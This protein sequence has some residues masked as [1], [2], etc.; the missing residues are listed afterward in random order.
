MNC[1]TNK[2]IKLEVTET[3]IAKQF[4]FELEEASVYRGGDM[5]IE[6][7]YLPLDWGATGGSSGLLVLDPSKLSLG[8]YSI[9]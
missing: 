7:A 8:R 1:Q 2:G 5:P 3:L 6:V 4:Y 9:G